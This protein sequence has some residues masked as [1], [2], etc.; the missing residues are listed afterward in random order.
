MT[1]NRYDSNNSRN[2]NA[3]D[4]AIDVD[5]AGSSADP[6][7]ENR[8]KCAENTKNAEN[9]RNANFDANSSRQYRSLTEVFT[10]D[11]SRLAAEA[12]KRVR[13]TYAVIGILSLL[14]GT[15]LLVRPE[16]T[17]QLLTMV[18][19][20]YFVVTAI[21]RIVFSAS[22]P[23]PG[24]WIAS[25]VIMG[26]VSFVAGILILKNLQTGT[27]ALLLFVTVC[28]GA[29]WII[30]GMTMLIGSA[31]L[32]KTGLTLFNGVI[33]VIAGIIVISAPMTS[34]V[35]LTWFVAFSLTVLGIVCLVRAFTFAR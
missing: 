12:I 20:L 18:V 28:T 7:G 11:M 24:G 32:F 3:G 23:L 22:T 31:G 1:D 4:E 10:I 25:E 27:Q 15:I 14:S 30:E 35:F 13:T 34:A 16:K 5:L 17:L 26:V 2:R 8:A 29:F 9:A 21:V 19:G 6:T 33:A